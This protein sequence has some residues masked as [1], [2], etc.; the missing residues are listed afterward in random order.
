MN[1][2][3][4]LTIKSRFIVVG[5]RKISNFIEKKTTLAACKIRIVQD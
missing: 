4:V 1:C 2:V 3:G 5:V